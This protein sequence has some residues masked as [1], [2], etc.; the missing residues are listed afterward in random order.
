MLP[1][2]RDL[3]RWAAVL[4][5]IP[6]PV[7]FCASPGG[8]L[9]N[10]GKFP[11]GQRAGVHMLVADPDARTSLGCHGM[12]MWLMTVVLTRPQNDADASEAADYRHSG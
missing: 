7:Q 5:E 10:L 2:R 8:P 9:H 12:K 6:C 1:S 3:A 4:H 11:T